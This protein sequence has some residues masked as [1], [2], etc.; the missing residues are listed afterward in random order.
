MQS[1]R[2]VGI[3]RFSH[4]R[5]SL[6]RLE[7]AWPLHCTA[8]PRCDQRFFGTQQRGSMLAKLPEK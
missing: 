3:C 7:I 1:D 4:R 8:W 5:T 2:L 6:R